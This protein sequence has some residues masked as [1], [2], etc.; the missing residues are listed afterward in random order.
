MMLPKPPKRGPKPRKRIP[1][2]HAGGKRCRVSAHARA[3]HL[4]EEQADDLWREV[5]RRLG[6]E[7]CQR[8]G[9]NRATES[10]HLASRGHHVLR[11]NPS[12]CARVCAPCHEI[13]THS[14]EQNERLAYR[15]LGFRWDVFKV[16]CALATKVNVESWVEYLKECRAAAG[17]EIKGGGR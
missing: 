10:H 5:T 2:V 12:N 13:V 14:K 17:V 7:M 6:P 4:L 1:R 9:Q 11:W 3:L 15:V 16:S 8:C